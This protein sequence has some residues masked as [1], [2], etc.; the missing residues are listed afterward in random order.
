MFWRIYGDYCKK[1]TESAFACGNFVSGLVAS[2]ARSQ[3]LRRS[4]RIGH[5]ILNSLIV[6]LPSYSRPPAKRH[7]PPIIVVTATMM[8]LCVDDNE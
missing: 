8:N 2:L 3:Q 5:H 1:F 7:S 6:T 4:F